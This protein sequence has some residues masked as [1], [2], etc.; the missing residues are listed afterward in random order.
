MRRLV[1]KVFDDWLQGSGSYY[2]ACELDPV[3]ALCDAFALHFLV[4]NPSTSTS[5]TLNIVVEHSGDRYKWASLITTTG[6]IGTNAIS[7]FVAYQNGS[8]PALPYIRLNLSLVTVPAAQVKVIYTGRDKAICYN[9]DR[10]CGLV[11]VTPPK[12]QPIPAGPKTLSIADAC[13]LTFPTNQLAIK[14]CSQCAGVYW[15]TYQELLAERKPKTLG[16]RL[17]VQEEAKQRAFP[18][19]ACLGNCHTAGVPDP[20]GCASN[21]ID[22]A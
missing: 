19:C 5:G 14:A 21:C 4:F 16:E 17:A 20:A 6:T 9:L 10:I 2:S 7:S 11:A 18:T 13:K 1:R 12:P 22:Q 8:L 15:T 3:M